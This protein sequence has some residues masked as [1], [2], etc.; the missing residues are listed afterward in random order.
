LFQIL[1]CYLVDINYIIQ[2]PLTHMSA[3]CISNRTSIY[4][5]ADSS[6]ISCTKLLFTQHRI[7]YLIKRP[8]SRSNLFELETKACEVNRLRRQ[9]CNAQIKQQLM[10]Y[11]NHTILYIVIREDL[12]HDDVFA[13]LAKMFCPQTFKKVQDAD[14]QLH[15]IELRA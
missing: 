15:M 2:P 4:R 6:R 5:F 9:N 3:F 11:C 7:R 8:L 12:L 13:I 1:S 14:A 10:L